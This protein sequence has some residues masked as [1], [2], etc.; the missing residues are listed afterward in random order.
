MTTVAL[1]LQ[2]NNQA[3]MMWFIGQECVYGLTSKV[4]CVLCL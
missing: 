4:G 1:Y 2:K 3:E